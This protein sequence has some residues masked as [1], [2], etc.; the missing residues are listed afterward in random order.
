MKDNSEPDSKNRISG[1]GHPEQD[2][3]NEAVRTG[4]QEHDSQKRTA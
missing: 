3:Q 2:F 4:Q 1:T